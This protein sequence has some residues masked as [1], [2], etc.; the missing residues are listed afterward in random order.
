MAFTGVKGARMYKP[1]PDWEDA[2]V[3]AVGTDPKV[4]LACQ[5]KA[6][7]IAGS[8]GVNIMR[9]NPSDPSTRMLAQDVAAG[10]HVKTVKKF[11]RKRKFKGTIIPVAL[12]VA[13]SWAARWFEVGHGARVPMTRFMRKAVDSNDSAGWTYWTYSG[14][15]E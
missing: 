7:A 4:Q 3:N 5:L 1:A 10:I 14:G 12:A 8:A 6:G 9:Y 13:D 2:V 11:T 15:G